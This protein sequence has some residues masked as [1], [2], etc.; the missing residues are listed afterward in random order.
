MEHHSLSQVEFWKPFLRKIYRDC[1]SQGITLKVRQRD[2]TLQLL[3]ESQTPLSKTQWVTNIRGYLSSVNSSCPD[4]FSIQQVLIYGKS[5]E[6]Q[7]LSWKAVLAVPTSPTSSSAPAS[8]ITLSESVPPRESLPNQA[9]LT[10]SPPSQSRSSESLPNQL[11]PRKSL[12][13]QSSPSESSASQSSANK[14]QATSTPIPFHNKAIPLIR[15]AG[16]GMKDLLLPSSRDRLSDRLSDVAESPNP[17]PNFWATEELS[18]L[19][20]QGW[21]ARSILGFFALSLIVYLYLGTWFIPQQSKQ[22][23]ALQ[24]EVTRLESLEP[25]NFA[26]LTQLIEDLKAVIDQLQS[27]SWVSGVFYERAQAQAKSLND[28]YDRLQQRL[29]LE[30][31]GQTYFSTAKYLAAQATLNLERSPNP[32]LN[33]R[34]QIQQ[35]WLAANYWLTLIPAQ[36]FAA[37][38]AQRFQRVYQKNYWHISGRIEE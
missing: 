3:L 22:L 11:S 7:S 27:L 6:T 30:Q 23:N 2:R 24:P 21:I 19:G 28:R 33:L 25:R 31:L 16:L 5:T 26:E 35:Q 32:D 8:S 36:T 29:E 37:K 12:P 10:E 17:T 38:D 20:S 13:S 1:I 14:S 34:R 9:A 4:P 18:F 15:P